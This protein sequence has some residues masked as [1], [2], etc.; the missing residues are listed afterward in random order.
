MS[1]ESIAISPDM[2]GR[3]HVKEMHESD[4][5]LGSATPTALKDPKCHIILFYEPVSTD[6]A[7]LQIWKLL[8]QSVAGPVIGAVN[9]SARAEIM[10][11]FASVAADL[12]NPLN[13][14]S[15]FGVPT[16]IVYR[17]R[18]PQAY[19]NGELSYDAI[20]KWILV[21]ACKP[22]YKEKFSE[23]H[24]VGAVQPDVYV[25]DSRIGNYPYPT[26]SR[27]FTALTGEEPREN[28]YSQ[29]NNNNEPFYE[30]TPGQYIEEEMDVGY[31][32]E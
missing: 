25:D 6:P 18:W 5:W 29:Y 26:S 15:G 22:G 27:D 12:D 24:G 20:K 14:F 9:T 28:Q 17:S 21:L 30:E 10:E 3:F 8:A 13:D 16:I 11:A 2:F 7:L 19:Y 32:S 4:F 31:L 23:F 1:G